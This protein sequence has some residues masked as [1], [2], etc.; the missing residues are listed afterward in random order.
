MSYILTGFTH[1]L[2]FR[3]F[4]FECVAKDRA[5]SA[6]KVRADLSL[7]RK[8]GIRVQELPLLCRGILDRTEDMAEAQSMIFTEEDMR[9]HEQGRVAIRQAAASKKKPPRRPVTEN[10]GSAWR[11]PTPP[12]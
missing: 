2:G 3:V 12:V 11:T 6:Y 9:V 1:D 5:R 8:Y 10:A 4:T 7:V